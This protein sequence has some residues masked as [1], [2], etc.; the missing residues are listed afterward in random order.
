MASTPRSPVRFSQD[1]PPRLCMIESATGIDGERHLQVLDHADIVDHDAGALARGSR[2]VARDR[3]HRVRFFIGLLRYTVLHAG[4]SKPAA[5]IQ[6][7]P[8]FA[9]RWPMSQASNAHQPVPSG[10]SSREP[11]RGMSWCMARS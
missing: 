3:L 5:R 6:Q 11:R 7:K 1:K 8:S 9:A 2:V 4:T 10:K